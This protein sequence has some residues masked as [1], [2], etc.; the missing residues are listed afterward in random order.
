MDNQT[1]IRR[2]AL[3]LVLVLIFV[4]PLIYY[5]YSSQPDLRQK[6]MTI[7][8]MV[9]GLLSISTKICPRAWSRHQRWILLISGIL[10]AVFIYYVFRI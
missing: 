2:V 6:L 10:F 8:L 9:I 5:T 7:T 3:L 1:G 4:L